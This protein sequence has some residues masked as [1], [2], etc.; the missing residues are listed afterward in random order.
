M[1]LETHRD[2]ALSGL[3]DAI[4]TIPDFRVAAV[5]RSERIRASQLLVS[6][7]LIATSAYFGANPTG[8]AITALPII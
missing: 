7:L 8:E 6:S 5:G 3:L 2:A 4:P 1:G